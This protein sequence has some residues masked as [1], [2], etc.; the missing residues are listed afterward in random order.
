MQI[1]LNFVFFE[2]VQESADDSGVTA[3]IE[4]VRESKDMDFR[5][6]EDAASLE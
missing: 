2:E 1:N 5:I 4:I 3:R 6:E